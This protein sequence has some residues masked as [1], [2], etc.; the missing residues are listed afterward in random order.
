MLDGDKEAD[1]DQSEDFDFTTDFPEGFDEDEEDSFEE[2]TR[3]TATSSVHVST[4]KD[5]S[6]HEG[7]RSGVDI[8]RSE[9]N[10]NFDQVGQFDQPRVSSSAPSRPFMMPVSSGVTDRKSVV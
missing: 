5:A 7:Q 3:G 10:F 4:P 6:R 2:P 1:A 8:D 9:F